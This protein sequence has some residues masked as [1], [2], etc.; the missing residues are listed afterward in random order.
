MAD[1]GEVRADLVGAPGLEPDAQQRGARAALDRPRNGCTASRGRS[2]RWTSRC[3]RARSRPIGASIVPLSASGR[4]VDERQ[5]LAPHL[6]RAQ[7]RLERRVGL[8]GLRHHQQPRRVAVEP[9]HDA[10]ALGSGPPAARPASAAP[11][12]PVRAPAP[13]ASTRPAGLSTTSRSLVLVDDLE[14]GAARRLAGSALR[15]LVLDLHA[16]ARRDAVVLRRAR[17]VH[18]HRAGIDQPLRRR[19][20]RRAPR[21]RQEGVQAQ[22]GVARRPPLAA[23][24]ASASPPPPRAAPRTPT[25]MHASATLKAGQAT[26]SMKSITA[27]SRARS[28]RLPSAP[29]S[30]SADRQPQPA[31]CP[32]WPRS[33]RSAAPSE[34]PIRIA[35]ISAAALAARRT[36][37]RCCACSSGPAPKNTLTCRRGRCPVATSCFVAWSTATTQ[38]RRWRAPQPAPLELT[39]P[40]RS[41]TMP[42]DDDQHEAWRRSG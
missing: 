21:A 9:V 41:A 6:A 11:A 10:G 16:L 14:S 15:L 40:D 28:A 4:P 39:S 30:S 8:L 22:A 42:L 12:W 38:R 36:R 26:G 1:R 37:R 24:R 7:L 19:A 25:T 32:G 35:T 29:P 17:P 27:P 18:Q 5:V 13:G 3:G 33:S 20:R 23:P 2:L 31:A 34:S